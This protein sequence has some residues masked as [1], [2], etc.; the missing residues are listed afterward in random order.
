MCWAKVSCRPLSRRLFLA[1][2]AKACRN[3]GF[4]ST[5]PFHKQP[6]TGSIKGPVMLSKPKNA[7]ASRGVS[8]CGRVDRQQDWS[9]EKEPTSGRAMPLQK[10]APSATRLSMQNNLLRRTCGRTYVE[11]SVRPS[12]FR[13][14]TR[15][16]N[17]ESF[18][19]TW[20]AVR[21]GRN[22]EVSQPLGRKASTNAWSGAQEPWP[23][24][25]KVLC[26]APS[27]TVDPASTSGKPGHVEVG[28]G[29]FVPCLAGP[30]LE[31]GLWQLELF[32]W[33]RLASPALELGLL[34]WP[35][36]LGLPGVLGLLGPGLWH[37]PEGDLRRVLSKASTTNPRCFMVI[38]KPVNRHTPPAL[39][40]WDSKTQPPTCALD[41]R[42]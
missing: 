30:A 18:R 9:G 39:P 23:V 24:M 21:G 19:R 42:F 37:L 22:G 25:V 29:R 11:E 8:V 6:Q 38:R 33:P 2:I 15:W 20:A 12:P 35:W 10:A 32:F 27:T 4:R 13:Q 28:F 31:L 5:A 40:E 7:A 14:R 26:S 41:S 1:G 34:V 16:S 17:Q 36:R 3:S